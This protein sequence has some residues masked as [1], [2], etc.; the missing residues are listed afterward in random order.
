[1]NQYFNSMKEEWVSFV[2]KAITCQSLSGHEEGCAD[3]FLN[4]M[5]KMGS[6]CFRDEVGN[7]VGVIRGTKTGPNILVTGHID[8]V[9]SGNLDAW[10]KYDPYQGTS[11]Q[12]LLYGR[13]VSD[14]LGGL[15]A[16]FFAFK[17]IKKLVDSGEKLVGNL[18]FAGVVQEE[19]AESLGA[20]YLMKH[21]LPEYGLGCD[22]VYLAEPSQGDICL[23]HR[24]KVELVVDVHGKVAHSSTP[25]DGVSALQKA[26][27][28]MEASYHNF[29]EA[30]LHHPA[31]DT[32]MAITDVELTPGK[33]YSC[34][35]DLCRIR[36]DRRY[37]PPM[38]VDDA[39]GQVQ[40]FI[41]G[42]ASED[43]DF[44][45]EV[46][47]GQNHRVCYTGFEADMPKHHPFWAVD[48]EN[49]YVNR[50]LKALE[51]VGQ[52]PK[53][54]YWTFGTDGSAFCG[55]FGITTIGYSC[56]DFLQAHQPKEHV[57]IDEMI[58]CIEGYTAILCDVYD[59]DFSKFKSK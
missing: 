6:E 16:A 49:E 59:M 44:R 28:L 36:I 55:I 57:V 38:T 40:R 2:S 33:T 30:P 43:P 27:P 31:G 32:S 41:D 8:V 11:D 7:A 46:Y 48:P 58:Q 39:I 13:G 24:G 10:G 50:A 15:S 37:V 54:N 26:L 14:M 52:H 20:I 29:Y 9:P 47:M 3:L 1:M 22:L 35:P 4:E 25:G 53:K 51:S 56:A 12:G 42:L 23:G 5:K 18:I 19:P 17:E 34:V 21:T 45:A